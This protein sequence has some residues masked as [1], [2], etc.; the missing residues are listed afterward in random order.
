MKDTAQAQEVGFC[1]QDAATIEQYAAQ[2]LAGTSSRL[3]PKTVRSYRDLYRIHIGPTLGAVRFAQLQRA[4]VKTLLLEKKR[5]GLSQNTVRLIGA[6]LSALCSEALDD[7]LLSANPG[8]WSGP[9]AEDSTTGRC[10]PTPGSEHG[11][12]I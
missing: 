3:R 11:R 9:P 6:C 7:G 5:Q 4:Q 2:W 12:T 10:S 8:S 1:F